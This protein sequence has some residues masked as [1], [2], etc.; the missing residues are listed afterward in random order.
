MCDVAS[1]H[2]AAIDVDGEVLGCVTFAQSYQVF[3]TMFLRNRLEALRMGHVHDS[4]FNRRWAKYPAAARATGLFTDKQK[5]Y[6]SYGRCG[7]CRFLHTCGIC[8]VSIGY[9]PDNTDPHRVLDFL[10]AY[11]L[12]ALKYRELFPIV[13]TAVDVLS[14][15][16]DLHRLLQEIEV[17]VPRQTQPLIN[18]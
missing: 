15:L 6:S 12:V 17:L 13:P 1:G 18:Y 9:Q 2:K 5:K 11:N 10:C 4:G 14:R 8:P 16:K 3:P 7:E